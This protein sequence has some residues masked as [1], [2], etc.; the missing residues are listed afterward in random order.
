MM[1]EAA[2]LLSPECV[3]IPPLHASHL[4]LIYR[5]RPLAKKI[6]YSGL[7]AD[8]MK[9]QLWLVLTKIHW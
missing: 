4:L 5:P 3:A 8:K 2:L 1:L 9:Q 7:R 6:G